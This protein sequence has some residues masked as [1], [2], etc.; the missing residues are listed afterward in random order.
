MGWCPGIDC[1]LFDHLESCNTVVWAQGANDSQL[2]ESDSDAW[3]ISD[4]LVH[5]LCLAKEF[6]K[7]QIWETFEWS[8]AANLQTSPTQANNSNML[9]CIPYHTIV[10]VPR[11]SSCCTNAMHGGLH[12]VCHDFERDVN[13]CPHKKYPACRI[14]IKLK[15]VKFGTSWATGFSALGLRNTHQT[16]GWYIELDAVLIFKDVL[17]AAF[18][19]SPAAVLQCWQLTGRFYSLQPWCSGCHCSGLLGLKSWWAVWPDWS[20][21]QQQFIFCWNVNRSWQLL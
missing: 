3:C 18:S 21:C 5:C 1:S 8:K 9:S 12:H 6:K 10:I 15:C 13:L 19:H 7:N 14:S 11:H 17:M 2:S 4:T 20:K 16:L